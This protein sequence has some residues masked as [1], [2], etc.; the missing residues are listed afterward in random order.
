MSKFL[1]EN[2]AFLNRTIM[3]DLM[4]QF[5]MSEIGLLDLVA[6]DG[7]VAQEEERIS[8][9][10]EKPNKSLGRSLKHRNSSKLWK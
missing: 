6:I 5:D 10:E 8:L 2:T 3:D 7:I 9:Q 4:N 1:A